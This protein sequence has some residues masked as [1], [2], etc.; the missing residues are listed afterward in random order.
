MFFSLLKV[1]CNCKKQ[2]NLC[3]IYM[4]SGWWAA[5][6]LVS[7]NKKMVRHEIQWQ[8]IWQNCCLRSLVQQTMC[9]LS[10]GGI[11][12]RNLIEVIFDSVWQGIIIRG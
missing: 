5:M 6:N 10:P 12:N 3:G 1:K 7:V 2:T 4:A 9:L 8:N 11:E